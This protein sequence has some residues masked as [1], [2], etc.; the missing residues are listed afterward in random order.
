MRSEPEVWTALSDRHWIPEQAKTHPEHEPRNGLLMCKNHHHRFDSYSFFIRFLPDLKKFV[1]IN[2]SGAF[3]DETFHG[4]VVA[5]DPRH[6]YAPFPSLF[7][8]QEMRV[9]GFHPFQPVVPSL[10]DDIVWQDWISSGGVLSNTD[11][12]YF[13]RDRR[14]NDQ[15]V[16]RRE[17]IQPMSTISGHTGGR[18]L[19][20]DA[21][22]IS[23]ILAATRAM[24]SWKAC[25]M[26]GTSWTGTAE[27]NIQKYISDIGVQDSA[28]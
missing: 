19:A 12:D 22:V 1:F 9:R 16:Q 27:E 4:K 21:D 6:H 20:L 25:Q 7:I 3:V 11:T 26:E 8:I 24:P 10:P 5:L 2:F 13:N 14:P 18:T 23:E 15:S 28:V 17:Q